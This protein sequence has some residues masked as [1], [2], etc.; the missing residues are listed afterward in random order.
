M[1]EPNKE[2]ATGEFCCCGI[3]W[4]LCAALFGSSLVTGQTGR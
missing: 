4:W 1:L 2:H 3:K